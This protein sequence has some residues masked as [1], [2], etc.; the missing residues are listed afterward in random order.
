MESIRSLYIY[1]PGPSSSHTI[2]PFNAALD[3]IKD[4]PSY[5][6]I[7]VDLYGSLAFTGK[8]HLTDKIII[9]ALKDY[10]AE[11]KFNYVIEGLP[12]PNTVTF[13]GYKNGEISAKTTYFSVGGG[14]IVKD[15][16]SN[17]EEG[18]EIYPTN[19]FEEIK[20][21]LK[22]EIPMIST[23][24]SI[25]MRTR[26]LILLSMISFPIWLIRLNVG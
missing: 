19:S 26:K 2:G 16:L 7:V 25:P 20:F 21:S 6:K 12:H 4:S 1:G 5:D 18:K 13:S 17:E 8:G 22:K 15:S 3:F 10:K 14:K 11:V 9:E 24:L 23:F